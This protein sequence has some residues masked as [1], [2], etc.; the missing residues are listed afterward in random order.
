MEIRKDL[1]LRAGPSRNPNSFEWAVFV[2]G[3][4]DPLFRGVADC[5]T[6]DDEVVDDIIGNIVSGLPHWLV[7]LEEARLVI[8]NWGYR[9]FYDVYEDSTERMVEVHATHKN[10]THVD[11]LMERRHARNEE[12]VRCVAESILCGWENVEE[13]EVREWGLEEEEDE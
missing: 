1:K 8:S 11:V 2:E 5:D 10:G 13:V 3:K 7:G 12:M 6:Q 9:V 4:D